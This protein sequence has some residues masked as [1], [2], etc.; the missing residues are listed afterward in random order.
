MPGHP[1]RSILVAFTTF[2]L[3]IIPISQLISFF[4][5]LTGNRAH[6]PAIEPRVHYHCMASPIQREIRVL[7][8]HIERLQLNID[9]LHLKFN[10]MNGKIERLVTAQERCNENL[11]GEL[12]REKEKG[13]RAM[14]VGDVD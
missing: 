7:S 2:G 14:Y 6:I 11:L 10:T 8:Q 9:L 12:V 3:T 13:G 5:R 4:V 1:I